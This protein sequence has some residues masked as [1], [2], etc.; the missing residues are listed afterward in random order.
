MTDETTKTWAS[1]GNEYLKA[2]NVTSNKE[3]FA[4]VDVSSI[5]NN[6][7]VQVVFKLQN[8]GIE[9]KFVCNRTNQNIVLQQCPN[10]PEQAIGK[11]ITFTKVDTQK[12]DGTP[13]KG[14]RLSFKRN[15]E[16]PKEVETDNHGIGNN[17][18]I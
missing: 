12:P 5:E 2:E 14:L 7:K 13:T 3:E 9:K 4:I 15:I 11:V 1:F 6:G 18:E 8:K 17:G 10:S 16:E